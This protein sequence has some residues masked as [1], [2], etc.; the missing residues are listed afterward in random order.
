MA[1]ERNRTRVPVTSWKIPLSMSY[2]LLLKIVRLL[3]PRRCALVV[4]DKCGDV[5]ASWMCHGRSHL[6]FGPQLIYLYLWAQTC[7]RVHFLCVSKRE[8]AD[9]QPHNIPVR[10]TRNKTRCLYMTLMSIHDIKLDSIHDILYMTWHVMYRIAQGTQRSGA[11]KN[12]S[13]ERRR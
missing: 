3:R 2:R 7:M 10:N 12:R 11:R 1:R 13:A 4:S 5:K 6:V 8:H 9:L